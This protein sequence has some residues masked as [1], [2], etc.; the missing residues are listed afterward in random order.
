MALNRVL[1]QQCALA[2]ILETDVAGV[3]GQTCAANLTLSNY[4]AWVVTKS[5]RAFHK[6]GIPGYY[7]VILP[8]LKSDADLRR[9]R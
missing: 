6:E 4:S 5:H 8:N 2:T 7:S 9:S 1:N 3:M